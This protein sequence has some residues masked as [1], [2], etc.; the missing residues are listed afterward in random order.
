M[1]AQRVEEGDRPVVGRQRDVTPVEPEGDGGDRQEKLWPQP[2][3]RDALGLV[4]A[5]PD[6]SSDSL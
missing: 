5:N 4:M 2:Q 3:V 6:C 1:V